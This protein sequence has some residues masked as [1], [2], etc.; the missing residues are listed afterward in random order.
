M[1]NDS[2]CVALNGKINEPLFLSMYSH[3]VVGGSAA[4]VVRIRVVRVARA[5]RCERI[6]LAVRSEEC[7]P[8]RLSGAKN[9][10]CLDI[11]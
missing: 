1:L 5:A 6:V 4:V 3:P 7:C 8:A 10:G 2:H 11:S 9:Q